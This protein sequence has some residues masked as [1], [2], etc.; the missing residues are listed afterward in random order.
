MELIDSALI[1]LE[2]YD[3]LAGTAYADETTP[4][5]DANKIM[6]LINNVSVS[7]EKICNRVLKARTFDYDITKPEYD[8]KYSIFDG[9]KGVYFYF[10]TYPVNSVTKFMINDIEI[11]VAT[12]YDDIAGYHLYKSQGKIAYYGGY[13]YAALS[14]RGSYEYGN[15]RNVKVKWNGGYN[16]TD[17]EM[18]ELKYLCYDMVRTL[19]YAPNNPNLQ[20]EKIGNYAYT[21]FSVVNLIAMKG[22]NPKVYSDLM[23][24]RKEV[25]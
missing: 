1:D 15:F 17:M 11:V 5:A 20:S 12:A 3:I 25:I 22:L 24:Y 9:P 18:E 23:R 2:Y 19:L 8:E 6:A 13:S 4:S 10:P 7:F 14:G 21:N 16:S